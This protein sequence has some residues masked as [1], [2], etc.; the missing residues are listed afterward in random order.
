MSTPDLAALRAWIGRTETVRDTLTP[1]LAAELAATLNM[2][3]GAAVPLA[4]HWCLGPPIVP[5]AAL[6][7]DG[8]PARGGFLPPVP[9]PRR[10]W[11]GSQLKFFLPL[12]IGDEV[13]RVS[14][15]ADVSIKQ[16]RSGALC[17]V[18]VAHE[19]FS[20]R[21]LAVTENHDIVYRDIV[22]PAGE[23]APPALPVAE[24]S[25][26]MRADAVLLFRYSAITFNGHRIHYDRA[27]ATGTENYP[28]LIVH[29]PLQ[30]SW[31]LEF[32]AE[33]KGSPPAQ[34]SFRGVSPLFDFAS[35]SLCA[36][37][38][39]DGLHLWIQTD[40]GTLTMDATAQW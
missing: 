8:H 16:G 21:G 20:A 27:Y 34:F 11:A 30:A 12:Q 37:A 35:F 9:L 25:R 31:L 28:G 17:F 10:M 6:G 14:R 15:I 36:R 29:G 3:E 18:T 1:R 7:P 26:R 39:D 19:F 33:M 2:P 38:V 4:A 22:P 32:A 5:A 13:E 40:E 24:W 23:K